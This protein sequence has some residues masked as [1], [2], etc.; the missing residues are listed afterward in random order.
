LLFAFPFQDIAHHQ[1]AAAHIVATLS[2][3]AGRDEF[4]CLA[5]FFLFSY[6]FSL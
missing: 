1:Q 5:G 3:E 4:W 6:L 2:Q